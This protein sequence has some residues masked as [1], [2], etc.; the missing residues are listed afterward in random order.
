MKMEGKT[1]PAKI[2]YPS[3]TTKN[4][5]KQNILPR[6]FSQGDCPTFPSALS[7][8]QARAKLPWDNLC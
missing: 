6:I 7:C 5:R 4:C 3:K 8:E 1:Y 2:I